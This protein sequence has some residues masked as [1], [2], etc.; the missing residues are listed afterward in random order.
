M[1]NR[2]S[3]VLIS[4]C[5]ITMFS[6]GCTDCPCELD[7]DG[8]CPCDYNPSLACCDPDT[9]METPEDECPSYDRDCDSMSN[10]TENNTANDY[11]SLDEFL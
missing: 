11:L 4:A 6:V 10:A 2:T 7:P 1:L 3:V 9:T 8:F 5:M